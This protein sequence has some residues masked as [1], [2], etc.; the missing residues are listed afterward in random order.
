MEKV[1]SCPDPPLHGGRDL[2]TRRLRGLGPELAKLVSYPDYLSPI[3]VRNVVRERD[4]LLSCPGSK[5]C[6]W[7]SDSPPEFEGE[8]QDFS[9][10]SQWLKV[11]S[12]M[13]RR[14]VASDHNPTFKR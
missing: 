2:G 5:F 6:P 7:P 14:E 11:G 12:K 10:T 9:G 1:V 3:G 13:L 4:E 8:L